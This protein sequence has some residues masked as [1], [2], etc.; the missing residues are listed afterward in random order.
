MCRGSRYERLPRRKPHLDEGNVHANEPDEPNNRTGGPDLSVP[1][2]RAAE[3]EG[4]GQEGRSDHYD[5]VRHRGRTRR[6]R[7]LKC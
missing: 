2:D 4:V 3:I 7:R 5:R 1:S 6:R